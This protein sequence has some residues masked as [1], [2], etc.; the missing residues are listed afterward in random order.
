MG[1]IVPLPVLDRF[2]RQRYDAA[3]KP[4]Y[5]PVRL[6]PNA[7]ALAWELSVLDPKTYNLPT[8]PVKSTR[9][10]K[11]RRKPE[12]SPVDAFLRDV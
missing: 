8:R 9:R 1:G 6:L 2:G 12:L 3:G 4:L 10:Q 7:A 11:P 5:R